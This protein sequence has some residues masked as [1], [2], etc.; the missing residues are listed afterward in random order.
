[1]RTSKIREKDMF[2]YQRI[3]LVDILAYCLMPNHFHLLIR[4]E[5]NTGTATMLMHRLCTA[6]ALYYNR[7]YGHSGTIFQGPYKAKYVETDMYH[8]TLLEYIHLN[9][10]SLEKSGENPDVEGFTRSGYTK[11]AVEYAK[12]YEYSSFKDYLGEVRPQSRILNGQD[13]RR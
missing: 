13:F 6:Y 12:Q 7:K 11:E 8:K 5:D 10:Y 2:K 1:M 4:E 9:P 3:T